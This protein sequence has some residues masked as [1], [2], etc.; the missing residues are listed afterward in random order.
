MLSDMMLHTSKI[1]ARYVAN[2]REKSRGWNLHS[3]ILEA[4]VAEYLT[5]AE[6]DALKALYA[7]QPR[8]EYL[9]ASVAQRNRQIRQ[10]IDE[11][12]MY[13]ERAGTEEEVTHDL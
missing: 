10:L 13:R 11:V 4:A 9:P 7:R 1:N 6:L 2:G 12:E 8:D 5:A 3:V